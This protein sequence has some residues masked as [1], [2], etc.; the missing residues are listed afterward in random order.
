MRHPNSRKR[1][2]TQAWYAVKV[3]RRKVV[4]REGPA[5]GSTAPCVGRPVAARSHAPCVA[6][7]RTGRP[8]HGCCLPHG[9]LS[10]SLQAPCLPFLL[11]RAVQFILLLHTSHAATCDT[12][13]ALHP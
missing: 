2:E 5:G 13:P 1:L 4:R 11:V 6:C 8:H 10:W 9:L 12:V 3:I 7:R